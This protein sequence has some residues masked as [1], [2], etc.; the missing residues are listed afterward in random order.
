[1]YARVRAGAPVPGDRGAGRL[2][3]R[4]FPDNAA[5]V[6]TYLEQRGNTLLRWTGGPAWHTHSAMASAE[7]LV[8]DGQAACATLLRVLEVSGTW[9]TLRFADH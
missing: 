9:A 5:A 8:N 1:M 7:K 3:G 2:L 4:A 6:L